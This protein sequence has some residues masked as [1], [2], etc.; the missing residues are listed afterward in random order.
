MQHVRVFLLQ[1]A[2]DVLERVHVFEVL[3]HIKGAFS[4]TETL[5][6]LVNEM[7]SLRFN[8]LFLLVELVFGVLPEGLVLLVEEVLLE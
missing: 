7:N 2:V 3:K 8:F 4:G 1:S 5:E 6:G